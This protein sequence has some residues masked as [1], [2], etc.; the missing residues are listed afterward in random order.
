VAY[1]I[2]YTCPGELLPCVEAALAA[3]GYIVT[4]TSPGNSDNVL[5]IM[6]CG[7]VEVL[8]ASCRKSTQAHIEV[9]GTAQ[10]MAVQLLESL[11]LELEREV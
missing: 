5:M 7:A 4:E 9:W 11:P 2:R 8:L 3:N 6:C 10:D 1:P